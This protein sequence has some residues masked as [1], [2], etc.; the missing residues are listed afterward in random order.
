MNVRLL[1]L[2]LN[3]DTDIVL[4][5][6]RTRRIAELIGFDSQ[7]QT[8]ITTATSEI[9]RNAL[10]HAKGGTV[11]FH[12]SSTPLHQ[13]L[14]IVISDRGPGIARLTDVLDGSVR[15]VGGMGVGLIGARRLIDDFAID[16]APDGGTRVRLVKQLPRRAPPVDQAAIKRIT[17]TLAADA[18]ANPVEEI[19]RQN[20][21]ML[22]QLG[23]LQTRQ[24][25]LSRINQELQETNRGVVAL[26]AELD[27]R[28]DHLRRADELKSRFLSNLSHEFRTPLNSILALSRLLLGRVDGELTGEQE[29]KSS[30]SAAPPKASPNW[31][32]TC[33]TW[34][35]WPL[36][37]MTGQSSL[38]RVLLVDDEEVSRYLV[39]QLLPRGLYEINEAATGTEGLALLRNDP[40]DIVL[41]DLNMPGMDGF[42]VLEQLGQVSDIPA[43]VLTSLILD[44][45]QR[46][47][48][49]RAAKILSK[50]DLSSSMLVA[51][52]G[53]ALGRAGMAA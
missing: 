18:P 34:Q 35:R 8:R 16:M 21:D 23:E 1:R 33:S 47:R 52:I 27:D 20:Q 11:E 41:L 40:P 32:T 22:L 24:E 46:L 28:A 6:K 10:E 3:S 9:A 26:Y 25:E 19:Q 49:G 5:R 17:Q 39:R 13:Q 2:P 42:Q 30:T 14:E 4:A 43:I 37:R 51:A 31:S 53:D 45:G 29:N 36:D 12:I 7:D 38:T 44:D 50:S 48:L 15:S